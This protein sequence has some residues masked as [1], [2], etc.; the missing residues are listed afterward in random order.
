VASL[1]RALPGRRARLAL[2]T[3]LALLLLQPLGPLG[4]HYSQVVRAGPTNV[5]PLRLAGLLERSRQPEERVVIDAT[6]QRYGLENGGTVSKALRYA[7]T[8]SQVPL[9]RLTV[10][11]ERLGETLGADR[12]ILLATDQRKLDDLDERFVLEP[13]EP[14]A[15][16]APP[17]RGYRVSRR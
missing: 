12:S 15:P 7:L 3:V 13:L 2:A 14:P 8:V 1:W 5:E 16:D 10:T 11:E 9:V 4:R 6:L 17:Y